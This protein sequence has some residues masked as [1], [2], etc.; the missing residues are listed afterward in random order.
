MTDAPETKAKLFIFG[1]SHVSAFS[2]TDE[3]VDDTLQRSESEDSIYMFQ[4]LGPCTAYN[5]FWNPN[6]YP[7]VLQLLE[8]HN[9]KKEFTVC[10]LLGEIDCRVH[11]GRNAEKTSRPI[12][13]CIEEVIDRY[14][15]CLLDLKQRGYRVLV[16]A[17]QPASTCP[18]S[19]N[20]DGPVHGH[21]IFRNL[22]TRQ[23]NSVLEYKSKLHGFLF[24][25]IFDTLME[26]ETTPNMEYF[27]DYV[28]L[29]GSMLRT[30]F[31]KALKPIL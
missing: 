3:I 16:F 5:F 9:P 19:T 29:R 21:F 20:P 14:L 6:Y 4:R 1:N 22:L 31:D 8:E 23:F 2:G 28:H 15:L 30:L 26:D 17:V 12:N 13:E 11:I 18:P 10:L 7:R 27:I 25:S 24:C